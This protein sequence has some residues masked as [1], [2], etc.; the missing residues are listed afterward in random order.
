MSREAGPSDDRRRVRLTAVRVLCSYAWLRRV[1]AASLVRLRSLVEAL[2]GGELWVDSG[3]FAAHT[4]GEVIP[5]DDYCA[6]LRSCDLPVARAF[7]LDVIG[8]AAR[9]EANFEA[10]LRQSTRPIPVWTRGAGF[11]QLRRF[12]GAADVVACGGIAKYAARGAYLRRMAGLL[13]P[14]QR[15]RL[16]LL[17][18]TSEEKLRTARPYSCDS[19]SANAGRRWG[20]VTVWAGARWHKLDRKK[21]RAGRIP[22]AVVRWLNGRGLGMKTLVD[23]KAWKGVF[24]GTA[25][26][27]VPLMSWLEYGDYLWRKEAVR[28]C[29][30]L[31]SMQE[32]DY[33]R[34][35]VD[36]YY[37]GG[38][39]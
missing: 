32:V 2:P 31:I 35:V 7:Q 16:H 6:F 12:L 36:A 33:L 34:H 27:G 38:N 17:G 11:E 15:G 23:E 29:V 37:E 10:M 28:L 30:V 3:A 4:V 5:L 25:T 13:T 8:D 39:Q 22:S 20:H 1:G 18:V 14:E 26:A 24:T 19:S 21:V 9:T